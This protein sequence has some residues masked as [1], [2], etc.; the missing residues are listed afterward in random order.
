MIY[1]M[2]RRSRNVQY[3]SAASKSAQVRKPPLDSSLQTNGP[4]DLL[5]RVRLLGHRILP[6]VAGR[7]QRGKGNNVTAENICTSILDAHGGWVRPQNIEQ[8]N[9]RG[10]GPVCSELYEASLKLFKGIEHRG[11]AAYAVTA[12]V[13]SIDHV[14]LL[15]GP[16]GKDPDS[17]LNEIVD[18]GYVLDLWA[19]ILCPASDY[20]DS[21]NETLTTLVDFVYV[22]E[23]KIGGKQFANKLAGKWKISAS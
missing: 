15:V 9:Q 23:K 14:A 16:A 8:K 22:N 4:D 5:Q 20:M 19:Y 6:A 11:F 3:E 1:R 18:G 2:A 13:G 12:K 10:D 17:D 7:V 21:F